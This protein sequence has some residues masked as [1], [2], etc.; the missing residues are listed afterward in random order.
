M[1]AAGQISIVASIEEC[2]VWMVNGQ[3]EIMPPLPKLLSP[4]PK[5][6]PP[7]PKPKTTDTIGTAD[8]LRLVAQ[9]RAR[10]INAPVAP[11]SKPTVKSVEKPVE[12][13]VTRGPCCMETCTGRCGMPLHTRSNV[14]L[15]KA[16][17][18]GH[19]LWGDLV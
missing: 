4:L 18:T 8:L 1:N 15:A 6:L 14:T 2:R 5:S 13:P 11:A 12:A 10:L 9:G 7:Q 16:V 19:I 3:S 17:R